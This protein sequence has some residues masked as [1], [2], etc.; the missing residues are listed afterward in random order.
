MLAASARLLHVLSLLQS[1]R[2]W[3]GPEL[4]REAGVGVRTIRRDVDR[5]RRLGYPIHA[6]PGVAGGYRLGAGAALPPL[7]LDDEE[8]VAVAVGLRT[9]ASGTVT[10]IEE[11]SMRALAK[12]EQVLP[13]RL[14]RRVR[15]VGSFTVP[16]LT[17]AP[18]VDADVLATIAAACRDRERLRFGY[19]SYEGEP[20]RRTV[21][22]HRLVQ[23]A[24]RWYVVAW[25]VDRDDWRSFRVDRIATRLSVGTRFP[26]RPAPPGGA[27]AFVARGQSAARDRWQATV[28]LH[29]SAESL[30][31]RVPQTVG[32]LEPVDDDTC[33]LHTGAD[34]LGGL[35]VYIAVIG[36]DFEVLGPPELVEEVRRLA[37]RFGRAASLSR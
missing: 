4:A 26:A 32:T 20:T 5:L 22:P 7:L 17:G 8:A 37:D 35:A 10:G 11:T 2:S 1:R 13:A 31:A 24:R 30:A 29:G 3:S 14:R 12:L 23:L 28:L 18:T 33:L 36:V 21:E 9:A 34:W 6:E 16:S 15:A 19:R 25:D 27:A